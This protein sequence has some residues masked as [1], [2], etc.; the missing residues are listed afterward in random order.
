MNMTL[1]GL[2]SSSRLNSGATM[3]FRATSPV[4]TAMTR[5]ST[6]VLPTSSVTS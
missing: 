1:A 2:L 6:Y 5:H 4:V 3:G